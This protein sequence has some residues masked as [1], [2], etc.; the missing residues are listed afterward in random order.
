M[1]KQNLMGVNVKNNNW[2]RVMLL[3]TLATNTNVYADEQNGIEYSGS[4]FAT[5][6]VGKMVGGERWTVRDFNCPCFVSDFAQGGIFDGSHDVQWK[7]DS[8]LGVQGGVSFDNRRFSINGQVVSRGAQNGKVDLEWLYASYKLNDNFTVN[9]GRKRIPLF[10]YSDTQ[11][12][13]VAL[14]WT[15]LPPG[16]Y[17]WEAVNYNG[18]DLTYQTQF[19]DWSAS[20]NVYAG[21][22]HIKDSQY[23]K[24]NSTGNQFRT[25][26]KWDN[27]VGGNMTLSKDWFE[28]RLSYLQSDTKQYDE[29]GVPQY[30]DANQR[31]YGWATNVDYNNWLAKTEFIKIGHPG[32]GANEY[33]QIVAVGYHYGK[34]QPMLT[35]G[36]YKWGSFDSTLPAGTTPDAQQAT[37][38]LTLRYDLTTSSDLKLQYDSVHETGEPLFGNARLV[39][40]TYDKVF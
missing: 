12:V 27:I 34:W 29:S 22:E 40:F 23:W 10:Y 38:A 4:G 32:W 17:G 25:E 19:K 26:V 30:V 5:L 20:G 13:G 33:A 35:W 11:D 21:S 24:V 14:P 39:S 1:I 36:Q 15:H 28:T 8:K 6:G 9:A 2:L 31:I 16:L 7:P 18:A 37:T 3:A